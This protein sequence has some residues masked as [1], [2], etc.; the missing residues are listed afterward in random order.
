MVFKHS[1]KC[2]K[3]DAEMTSAS[4]SIVTSCSLRLM[5]TV[6]LWDADSL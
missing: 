3:D 1:L 2:G 4:R 6:S 5:H